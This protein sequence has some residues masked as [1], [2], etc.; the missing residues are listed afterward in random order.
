MLDLEIAGHVRDLTVDE[1]AVTN[2][3]VTIKRLRDSHHAVARALAHGLTP[4][5]TSLQTGYALSRISALQRDP[6][7]IELLA[8]YRRDDDAV[9]MTFEYR[10]QLLSEDAMQELHERLHDDPESFTREELMALYKLTAD[11]AGFAPVTRSV[12]KSVN[13]NIGTQMDEA[14]RRLVEADAA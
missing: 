8:G 9:R 4:I 12:T 6:S 14:R 3:P 11:R 13:Y 7:F 10:S 5:Q 1:I 2:A